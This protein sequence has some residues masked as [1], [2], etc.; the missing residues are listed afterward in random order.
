M[1]KHLG[2]IKWIFVIGDGG[3]LESGGGVG[4]ITK[5]DFQTVGLL[6]RG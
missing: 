6:E 2:R 5:I 4:F 1:K 3:L